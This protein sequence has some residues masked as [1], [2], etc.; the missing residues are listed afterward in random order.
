MLLV[1]DAN[2]LFS[3]IIAR[4]KTAD[5]VFSERL[6]LVAPEF[7]F[8]ELREHKKELLAKSSLAEEDFEQLVSLLEERIDVIPRQE[9]E[10]FLEEANRISPDPDDTEYLAL[11]LRLGAAVWSNDEGLKR[12]SRVRVLTTAELIGLLGREQTNWSVKLQRASRRG[13]YA[14]LKKKGLV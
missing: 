7:L 5:L 11:A 6:E 3:A 8:K 13:R 4:G 2:V 12:Q 10:R 9:F 14:E 1:V